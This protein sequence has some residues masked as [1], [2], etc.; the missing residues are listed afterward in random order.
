MIEWMASQNEVAELWKLRDNRR[1]I[2]NGIARAIAIEI[3]HPDPFDSPASK[4]ICVQFFH[5]LTQLG[6][7]QT[8]DW[9][10]VQKPSSS[11]VVT[12]AVGINGRGF[13]KT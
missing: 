10:F 2:L 13:A 6:I 3:A 4:V 9:S 1:D 12:V 11:V 8:P 5:Q 7:A